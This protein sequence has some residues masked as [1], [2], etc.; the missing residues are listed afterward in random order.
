MKP[1]VS[2]SG[3]TSIASIAVL[4]IGLAAGPPGWGCSSDSDAGDSDAAADPD[5]SSPGEFAAFDEVISAFLEERGLAGA[6]AVIVDRDQGEVYLRGYG[7]FDAGRLYLIA[8]SSKTISVGVL[9]HLADQGLV[10]LDAPIGTYV[11]A[12]FGDGDGKAE[13]TLAQLL[14]NSSGLVSLTD[15]P[16]YLPYLCQYRGTGTLTECAGNIYVADDA[17]DRVE[18]DT[19][20]HYGGGQWQLAGGVAEVV[21][22]KSWAELVEE[23][24]AVPCGTGSLGYA[25]EFSGSGLSYPADFDGDVANL[26]PTENPSVEGGA[27]ITAPDYGKL[28]LMH[29]RGGLCGDTRALSEEAVERMRVDRIQE[30]YGGSTSGYPALQ[31]YGLGWWIDRE[32]DGVVMDPGA[33]GAIPWLDLPRGYGAFVALEATSMTGVQLAERAKPVLDAIFDAR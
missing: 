4:F 28:L 6:S 30:V 31:G 19:S 9:M 21:S 23:T 26:T 24:F 1:A 8:S 25:N 22:A 11:G 18:P 3:S 10:D 14:S 5:A 7:A 17:A 16:L 33:Y 27:Y 15:N 29:L 32:H 12:A 2:V 13:L 20:F